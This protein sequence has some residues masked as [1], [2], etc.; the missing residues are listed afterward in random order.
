[1][2]ASF[3]LLNKHEE[4]GQKLSHFSWRWN[5]CVL[6]SSSTKNWEFVQQ[7]T[8]TCFTSST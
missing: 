5:P 6:I 2:W 4:Q 1:V 3:F 7:K 8:S